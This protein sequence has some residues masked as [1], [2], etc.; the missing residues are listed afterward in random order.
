MTTPVMAIVG[1]T[2]SLEFKKS[3]YDGKDVQNHFINLQAHIPEG[4]PGISLEEALEQS[5]DMH[6]TAYESLLGTELAASEIKSDVFDKRITS[7][8]NRFAKIKD[9]TK[10]EDAS[11]G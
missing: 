8:R 5:L 6:L 1:L 2:V 11:N 9:F 7:L 3:T 10:K 4:N